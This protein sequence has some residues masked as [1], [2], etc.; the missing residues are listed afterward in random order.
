M[1]VLL[2]AWRPRVATEVFVW[3]V[4]DM[5]SMP[6]CGLQRIPS[7]QRRRA[8]CPLIGANDDFVGRTIYPQT[9]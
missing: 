2:A 4:C 9:C 8:C 1:K 5:V 7:D 6:P 3:C